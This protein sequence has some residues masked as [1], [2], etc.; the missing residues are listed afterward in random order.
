MP[1]LIDKRLKGDYLLFE[2]SGDSMDDGTSTMVT[3]YSAVS[4]LK[5]TGSME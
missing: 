3:C 5:V 1:V 4:F 2:V